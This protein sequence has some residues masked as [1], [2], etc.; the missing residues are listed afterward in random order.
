M[1]HFFLLTLDMPANTGLCKL[2]SDARMD[3]LQILASSKGAE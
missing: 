2:F 1:F 3:D